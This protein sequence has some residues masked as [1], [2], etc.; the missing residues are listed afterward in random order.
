MDFWT[1]LD[2]HLFGIGVLIVLVI[3]ALRGDL[4]N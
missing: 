2:H 4:F 1:F 3:A